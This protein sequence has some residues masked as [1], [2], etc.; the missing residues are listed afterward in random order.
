MSTLGQIWISLTA[1]LAKN[2]RGARR[3]HM[4]R[5]IF[6][7]VSVGLL[8]MSIIVLIYDFSVGEPD[9]TGTYLMLLADSLI[10]T[11][12]LLICREHWDISRYLLPAIFLALGGY[13]FYNVGLVTTGVLQLAIAIIL[14][15]LLFG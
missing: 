7:M 8:L 1:P 4:T 13:F 11:G 14:T 6:V 15:A 12:W 2:E 10:F 5:V 3:E 9:Y